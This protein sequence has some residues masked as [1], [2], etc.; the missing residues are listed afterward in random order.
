M[1]D[2]TIPPRRIL[3]VMGEG[4]GAAALETAIALADHHAAEIEIF[5][6]VQPPHDLQL[7]AKLA[8]RQADELLDELKDRRQSEIAGLLAQ[9]GLT[10]SLKIHLRTGKPFIEV[11]RFVLASDIDFV[12]KTAEPLSSV[13]RFLFGSTDQHL[14]RKC[15][16]PVWLVA[17]DANPLP[18]TVLAAVDL[19]EE[20]AAEPE[21]LASLNRRVIGMALHVA[22]PANAEVF[23]LHGWD[24]IGEGLVWAFSTTGQSAADRYTREIREKRRRAMD[25][26]LE[27]IAAEGSVQGADRIVPRLVKGPPEQVIAEQSRKLGAEVLVMGTVA[28]TGLEG[29]IIGN[30]A[31]NIINSIEC[32]VLAVKPDGFVSPIAPV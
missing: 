22:G 23:V 11:I 14:L 12:V 2:V 18:R 32:P 4:G 24:A 28:R 16:C 26:L 27:E 15:P 10:R 31:E 5:T 6:C 8:G 17:P 7:L 13:Q 19:D 29:V 21:T 30:T 1:T 25:L 3:V 9:M 20:N